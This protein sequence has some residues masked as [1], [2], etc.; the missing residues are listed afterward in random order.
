MTSQKNM[1]L[2]HLYSIDDSGKRRGITG[3]EA[4]GLYRV[5]SL[6]SR[7]AELKGDGYRIISHRK[8]DTTGKTYV[9]Y[10]LA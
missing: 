4:L 5:V 7:I 1:I 9:R 10:R 2:A 6:T 3:M 8:K